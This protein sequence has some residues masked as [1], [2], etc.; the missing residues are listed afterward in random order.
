MKAVKRKIEKIVSQDN[1]E[2]K[3]IT[4]NKKYELP[5]QTRQ[6]DHSDD[7]QRRADLRTR[8]QN[9]LQNL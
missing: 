9:I 7:S 6:S 8:T 3:H 2:T 5:L 4:I 1:P